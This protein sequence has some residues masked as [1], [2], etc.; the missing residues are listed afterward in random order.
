V[1]VAGSLYMVGAKVLVRGPP[2][3]RL[4]WKGA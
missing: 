3:D 1:E 4:P 2:R